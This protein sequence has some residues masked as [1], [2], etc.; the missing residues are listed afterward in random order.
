MWIEPDCN[1]ISVNQY[2]I[3][4]GKNFHDEFGV[5]EQ[6]LIPD[7][8]GYSASMPQILKLG[9]LTLLT[10]DELEPIQSLSL[11]DLSMAWD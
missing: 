8:F 3:L 11:L 10:Q 5:D 1:L 2:Q 9:G 6:L 7:A 4:R